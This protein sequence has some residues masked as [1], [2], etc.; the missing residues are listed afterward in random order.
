MEENL[1]D[2][3]PTALPPDVGAPGRRIPTRG[4]DV[5][6]RIAIGACSGT[7][8]SLGW[9][10]ASDADRTTEAWSVILCLTSLTTVTLLAGHTR[11]E[12]NKVRADLAATEDRLVAAL[13]AALEAVVVRAAP[14]PSRNRRRGG[15]GSRPLPDDGL[16]PDDLRLFLLGRDSVYHDEDRDAGGDVPV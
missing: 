2:G 1:S 13:E 14:R 8:V 11:S 7:L 9:I 12:M 3:L 5:L 6:I 10:L 15:A 16:L 4:A